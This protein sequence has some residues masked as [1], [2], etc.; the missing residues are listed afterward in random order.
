[1][2]KE[3]Q[4]DEKTLITPHAVQGSGTA[5]GVVA[6]TTGVPTGAT[7]SGS[8]KDYKE[9]GN[10]EAEVQGIAVEDKHC[11]RNKQSPSPPQQ[12][13]E[14]KRATKEYSFMNLLANQLA[15][16]GQRRHTG[17]AIRI[18]LLTLLLLLG[19]VSITVNTR[20]RQAKQERQ[21][22]STVASTPTFSSIPG[23]PCVLANPSRFPPSIV[24]PYLE[25]VR[26]WPVV[27]LRRSVLPF[28]EGANHWRFA[29][30]RRAAK[31]WRVYCK[32]T[33]QGGVVTAEDERGRPVTMICFG[34][35]WSFTKQWLITYI[36]NDRM[37]EK[38]PRSRRSWV[39][40]E[41]WEAPYT[42]GGCTHYFYGNP[43]S[44]E[45]VCKMDE[46]GEKPLA[47]A[48]V[49]RY[50]D[51][52]FQRIIAKFD[53]AAPCRIFNTPK[54]PELGK[55]FYLWDKFGA[56]PKKIEPIKDESFRSYDLWELK[57]FRSASNND[58]S[59]NSAV[60]IQQTN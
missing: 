43:K 47:Y 59:N 53:G 14:R 5:T 4:N 18:G 27:V 26:K 25:P 7:T 2:K 37:E 12:P 16:C 60:T 55:I 58:C 32:G 38:I 35:G 40:I 29:P 46:S 28:L 50:S 33:D 41:L 54:A 24:L 22:T 39:M 36:D 34:K 42:Y 3:K 23:D 30:L 19:V 21:I 20:D 8:G 17:K 15:A 56:V 51:G 49:D 45:V 44:V 10:C 57:I 11:G 31:L 52:N 48:R 6:F 1:M 9:E 13:L